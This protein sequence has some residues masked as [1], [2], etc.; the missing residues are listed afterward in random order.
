MKVVL[1]PSAR[2]TTPSSMAEAAPAPPRSP[3]VA[4][5]PLDI[6]SKPVEP[7]SRATITPAVPPTVSDD[8][9]ES[10]SEPVPPWATNSPPEAT[11]TLPPV[12]VA[13]PEFPANDANTKSPEFTR[14]APPLIESTPSSPPRPIEMVSPAVSVPPV[15]VSRPDAPVAVD[16]HTRPE[17]FTAPPVIAIDPDA[18]VAPPIEMPVSD[19]VSAVSVP[20][21]TRSVARSPGVS[22]T[23]TWP[24]APT[25]VAPPM[26]L[27]VPGPVVCRLASV[28]VP[29]NVVMPRFVKAA[30]PV[31]R[32][33]GACVKNA[34][35]TVTAD[36]ASDPARLTLP[37]LIDVAPVN[38]L[39]LLIA[40]DPR[41][42]LMNVPVPSM[43]AVPV[44]V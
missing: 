37:L 3:V 29:E 34:A 16:T 21:D 14:I 19:V 8:A 39:A 11:A 31:S 18:V 25:V 28:F 4:S 7:A 38:V 9:S 33:V 2:I 5:V 44:S 41:P 40:S 6:V 35:L 24:E 1:E 12:I 22:P 13:T 10:E 36:V 32:P 17:A 43:P 23:S 20:P 27:V 26:M 42:F 15:I 30:E